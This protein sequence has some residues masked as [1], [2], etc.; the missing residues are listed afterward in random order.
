MLLLLRVNPPLAL[1]DDDIVYGETRAHPEVVARL[2]RGPVLTVMVRAGALHTIGAVDFLRPV[3][4]FE[5][6]LVQ[7]AT[8][9]IDEFPAPVVLVVDG[10]VP[11]HREIGR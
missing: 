9:V 6:G 10:Y 7:L 8:A 1:R 3:L 11:Q 4:R 2:H 5:G